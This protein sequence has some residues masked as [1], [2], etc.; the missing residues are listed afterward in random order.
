[1]KYLLN[2]D[3]DSAY[4]DPKSRS[5][6]EDSNPYKVHFWDLYLKKPAERNEGVNG[7]NELTPRQWTADAAQ[8]VAG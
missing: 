6:R 5:M 3:S 8:S 2:L 7:L 4:Y 1:M